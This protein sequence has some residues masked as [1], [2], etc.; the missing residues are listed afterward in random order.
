MRRLLIIS[1]LTLPLGLHAQDANPDLRA[2]D[3]AYRQQQYANAAESYRKVLNKTPANPVAGYN[4]G[5]ALFKDKRNGEAL[6]AYDQ[7]IK[8]AREAGCCP[9][10][11]TTKAFPWEPIR[12]WRRA[13]TPTRT[14]SGSTLR[15]PW[16]VRTC[17]VR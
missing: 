15:T 8:A 1:M 4:L 17:N 2:G 6:Q 7:A 10:P 11:G 14:P 13:S 12:N 9:M 16:R 3:K 5:N